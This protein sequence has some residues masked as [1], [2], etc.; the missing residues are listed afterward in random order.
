[1]IA[2]RI[3]AGTVRE[4]K[5]RPPAVPNQFRWL[6]T[7][8]GGSCLAEGSYRMDRKASGEPYVGE[9]N[10]AALGVRTQPNRVL[11]GYHEAFQG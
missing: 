10:T 2:L 5:A 6:H 4:E 7:V 11:Q 8:P 9:R 3:W 1:M